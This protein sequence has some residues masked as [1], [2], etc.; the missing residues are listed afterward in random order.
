MLGVGRMIGG[1]LKEKEN[2]TKAR[3]SEN[4]GSVQKT[5]FGRNQEWKQ[6]SKV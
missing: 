3:N 2:L 5:L 1:K 4:V 6:V